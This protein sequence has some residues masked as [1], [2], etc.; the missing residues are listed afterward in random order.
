MGI[1]V[2]FQLSSLSRRG[3]KVTDGREGS[4]GICLILHLFC[5]KSHLFCSKSHLFCPKL[6]LGWVRLGKVKAS[7]MAG[8]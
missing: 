4:S 2:K 7:P 8:A 1:N 3:L 6:A 5:P